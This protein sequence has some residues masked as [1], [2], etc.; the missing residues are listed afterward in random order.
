MFLKL[1]SRS[2]R[3]SR[4]IIFSSSFALFSIMPVL[5]QDLKVKPASE[6]DVN[7]YT[8]MI[9]VNICDLVE[10]KI[11]FSK[12]FQSGLNTFGWVMEIRHGNAIANVDGGNK[13]SRPQIMNGGGIQIVLLISEACGDKFNGTDR[14]ELDDIIRK[15]QSAAATQAPAHPQ[16]IQ[17]AMPAYE[18]PPSSPKWDQIVNSSFISPSL[19][20]SRWQCAEELGILI[21]PL[22]SSYS[23]PSSYT[24]RHS[25]LDAYNDIQIV[26]ALGMKFPIYPIWKSP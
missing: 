10:N 2:K 23:F 19:L 16:A 5:P 26:P 3:I 6:L 4:Y 25:T 11:S 13:I 17:I 18:L 9:A 14:K 20:P 21:T 7:T 8:R 1:F 15:V 22:K 24:I 12:A